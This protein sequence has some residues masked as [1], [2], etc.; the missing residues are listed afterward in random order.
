MNGKNE[1]M[2]ESPDDKTKVLNHFR[3]NSTKTFRKL[4]QF[5]ICKIAFEF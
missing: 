3:D 4:E 5:G 2:R 1:S